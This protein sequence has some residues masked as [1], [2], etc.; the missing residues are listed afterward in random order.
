[1]T[2]QWLVYIWPRGREAEK[3]KADKP[4]VVFEEVSLSLPLSFPVSLCLSLFLPS[5]FF[6]HITAERHDNPLQKEGYYNLS[7]HPLPQNRSDLFAIN[8]RR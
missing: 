5:F 1:M 6:C 2:W 8:V 7:F 3:K 4:K